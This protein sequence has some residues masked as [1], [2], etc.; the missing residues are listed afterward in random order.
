[1]TRSAFDLGGSSTF[2]LASVW[3][4]QFSLLMVFSV[5]CDLLRCIV[6]ARLVANSSVQLFAQDS[7][8]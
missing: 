6:K 8:S 1:M 2:K 3:G 4:R 7:V 5:Y